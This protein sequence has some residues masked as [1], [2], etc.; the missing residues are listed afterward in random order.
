MREEPAQPRARSSA[1]DSHLNNFDLIRILAATQVLIFHTIHVLQLSTPFWL[2]PLA[3]FPGVTIFFVVSGY[4]VSSS[5]E[6]SKSPA[7]Y[8]RKRFL[9]IYPGLW[10]CLVLTVIVA[11][12]F[13][14][15]FLRFSAVTWFVAQLAGVI[16]TPSFLSGFGFG[17]YN[18]SLWTIPIELQFYCLVPITYFLARRT[19]S[20]NRAFIVIFVA[21][22]LI[23][24]FAA[25]WMPNM[26]SDR[27]TIVEKL[28]R[29]SFVPQFFLFLAGVV[30]QRIGARNS[31]VIYGKAFFWIAAYLLFCHFVQAPLI[32]PV[33]S[34]LLLAVCIISIAYTLPNLANTL[35]RGNDISYGVYIYHGLILNIVVSLQLRANLGY[36]LFVQVL[37]CMLGYLSWILVERRFLRKKN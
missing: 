36:V 19:G 12:A 1:R 11:T 16:Y 28:F 27:E 10:A 17:S 14:F 24:L 23:A 13:G 31:P 20:A 34:S 9:R 33:L 15:S 35:L 29:Y 37:A 5:Y 25:W 4:L 6:R 18:G 32:S 30:L 3:N 7:D 2:M 21:F 22:T 26:G 8:F